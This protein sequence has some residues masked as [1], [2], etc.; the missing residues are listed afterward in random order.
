MEY[1]GRDAVPLAEIN[2]DPQFRSLFARDPK[3]QQAI[4]RHIE[5]HGY[6]AGQ[7]ITI[8]RSRRKRWLTKDVVIDGHTRLEAARS[9]GVELV[10]VFYIDFDTREEALNYAI[11]N[12]R[13]RRNLTDAEILGYVETVNQKATRGRPSKKNPPGG[14]ILEKTA[15]EIAEETGISER[16]AERANNNQE[17]RFQ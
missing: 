8:A 5:A 12:Q 10:P 11:H 6:D 16:K 3:T 13:D 15:K 17:S 14:G 7:P 9:A 4:K 2:T 1:F